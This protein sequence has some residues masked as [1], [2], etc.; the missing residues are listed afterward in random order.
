MHTLYDTSDEECRM[1][2]IFDFYLFL[3][4]RRDLYVKAKPAFTALDAKYGH[5]NFGLDIE[6]KLKNTCLTTTPYQFKK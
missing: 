3:M 4:R 5:S 1:E 6:S 2:C